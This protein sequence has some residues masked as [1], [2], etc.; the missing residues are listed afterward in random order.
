MW[1]EALQQQISDG[2]LQQLALTDF[3][4]IKTKR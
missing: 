1:H 2:A 3:F 4:V